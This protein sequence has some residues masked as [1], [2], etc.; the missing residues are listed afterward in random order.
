MC[1]RVYLYIWYLK[2]QL[3]AK[4]GE[5]ADVDRIVT[6]EHRRDRSSSFSRSS[7]LARCGANEERREEVFFLL[8]FCYNRFRELNRWKTKMLN[9][10]SSPIPIR[11]TSWIPGAATNEVVLGYIHHRWIIVNWKEFFFIFQ[12][13]EFSS[14]RCFRS[15]IFFG[16]SPTTPVSRKSPTPL[17]KM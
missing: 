4:G 12:E 14:T 5:S 9:D 8:F 7:S 16:A 15:E 11:A 1:V 13:K 17:W 2:F 6:N 10:A 3:V